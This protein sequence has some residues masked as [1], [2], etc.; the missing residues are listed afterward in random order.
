MNSPFMISKAPL[1]IILLAANITLGESS[2]MNSPYMIYKPPF[3]SVVLSAHITILPHEQLHTLSK[4]LSISIILLAD[5]TVSKLLNILSVKKENLKYDDSN[6]LFI[7]AMGRYT[8]NPVFLNKILSMAKTG[9][10][11]NHHI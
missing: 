4:A 1:D 9:I 6:L 3:P 8:I 7:K 11:W 10:G 2:F 5:I